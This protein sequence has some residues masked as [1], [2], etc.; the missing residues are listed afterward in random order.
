MKQTKQ[1]NSE[2]NTAIQ[3]PFPIL[4]VTTVPII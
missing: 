1:N 4:K 2:Q 3:Q